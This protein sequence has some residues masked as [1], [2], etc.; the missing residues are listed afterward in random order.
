MLLSVQLPGENELYSSLE[1]RISVIQVLQRRYSYR[2]VQPPS[3]VPPLT[4]Q[5]SAI[6]IEAKPKVVGRFQVTTTKDPTE[7]DTAWSLNSSPEVSQ[8]SDTT[9]ELYETASSDTD[10]TTDEET[11]GNFSEPERLT[12]NVNM[13]TA[14]WDK[15]LSC[16]ES[17]T[18]SQDLGD[19]RDD[20]EGYTPVSNYGGKADPCV[21]NNNTMNLDGSLD[22]STTESL[23]QHGSTV[24][25][26][27]TVDNTKV[28]AVSDGKD[29]DT[30]G[31]SGE[32]NTEKTPQQI[33]TVQVWLHY[34]RGISYV[35]S[36]D[37]ESEDEEIFEELQQLRQKH[38][39]EVQLLQALQ[40]KEIE[41]LYYRMGKVPPPG[42][43]SPAAML[44]SRQ[45]RLSKGS[46]N[47]SRRNSLQRLDFLPATGIRKN[48]IGGSSTGSQDQRPGKGITFTGDV[49][50]MVT[51]GGIHSDS[52]D[53]DE[54]GK[55]KV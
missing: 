36:D 34:T 51:T 9:P 20:R 4:P 28:I 24:N 6:S 52:C 33:S 30:R 49:T 8:T 32:E 44:S 55:V 22:N 39:S 7:N 16:S 47:P 40:K 41:E 21:L 12:P 43:V 35:S 23:I 38:M 54:K 18:C 17:D 31:S 48:S 15:P 42:I 3:P 5:P 11:E 25:G 1:P 29:V 50:R 26:E 53:Q 19:L 27:N 46:F 13:D 14:T 37:T 45:R 2:N 10:F